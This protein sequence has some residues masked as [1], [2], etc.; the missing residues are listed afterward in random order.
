MPAAQDFMRHLWY[1][2]SIIFMGTN[3]KRIHGWSVLLGIIIALTTIASYGLWAKHKNAENISRTTPTLSNNEAAYSN[4]INYNELPIE[5]QKVIQKIKSRDEF[6]FKQDGRT[7][8]NRESRLPS[9]SRGYYQ[10]YTVVTPGEKN[11]GARRIVA[12]KGQTK[13]VATS[14]EYYYTSNHYRSF[15]QV[16]KL[17]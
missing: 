4:S 13:D 10:E 7:F 6:P 15:Y 17:K 14:N 8:Q 2:S 16:K 1:I 3:M 5:A 12:G 11:R 9:K